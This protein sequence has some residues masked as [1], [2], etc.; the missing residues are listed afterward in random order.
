MSKYPVTPD[1]AVVLLNAVLRARG[2]TAIRAGGRILKIMSSDKAKRANLPVHFGGDP[3]QIPDTDELITQVIPVRSVDAKKLMTDIQP[4]VGA[5]ADITSNA[6]SNTIVM[7][8]TSANIHRVVEIISA[9]DK[10]DASDN[11]IHVRHLA[12]CRCHSRRQADHGY[13]RPHDAPTADEDTAAAI[14][15][16]RVRRRRWW[17]AWWRW[18]DSAAAAVVVEQAEPV[19]L[20]QALALPAPMKDKPATSSPPPT[21]APTPSLSPAPLDTLGVID[22]VLDQIDANPAADQTFFLYAVK[23]GQ[24][25]D[26]Q[27]TL[28]ALFS[29]S[30]AGTGNRTNTNPLT[31]G[32]AS[33]GTAGG[34]SSLGGRAARWRRWTR[35][36][37]WRRT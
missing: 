26:M 6:G 8:D 33:R 23:N 22:K 14:L 25:V 31:S 30:T 13:L 35:W 36:W 2:Y 16:R 32:T 29:G 1:E 19:E 17:W 9:M 27:A 7:T 11:T 34:T 21:R 24:A 3:A 12:V 18:T 10:R 15:P 28:N 5:D 20:A 37:W 4:L